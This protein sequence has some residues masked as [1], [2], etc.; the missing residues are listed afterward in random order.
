M[1]HFKDSENNL[2]FIE[3][4]AFIRLLPQGC[5]QITDDEAM[6]LA[7]DPGEPAIAICDPWQIRK[8]LTAMG[9]RQAVED[10][11][12]AST[13]QS[14]KDGW[15]FAPRFRSDDPFVLAMGATLGKSE[16]EIYDLVA[17]AQTL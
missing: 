7:S 14:L 3:D 4:S 10:A 6:M 9:L 16:T 1:P 17:L 11:V 13:D 5:V 12:A 2:Y 8:A 15:E